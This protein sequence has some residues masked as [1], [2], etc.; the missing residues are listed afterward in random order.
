M[1]Y[2]VF[3]TIALVVLFACACGT[4][5]PAKLQVNTDYDKTV[6]WTEMKSFRMTS[7]RSAD[8]SYQRHPK[9]EEMVHDSLA[10]QLGGR[11][12][13]RTDDGP[14]DFRVAF[15]LIFRGDD[16]NTHGTTPLGIDGQPSGAA[17]PGQTGALIVRMLDPTTSR[18][19]WEGRVS[20]FKFGAANREADLRKAVWRILVEF[21]PITG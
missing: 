5:K 8:A 19:L 15:E 1:K 6:R 7:E 16:T 13:K 21:P 17:G 9:L 18:V 12:F 20:E 3:S 10:E 4:T 2:R 14:T 11:G